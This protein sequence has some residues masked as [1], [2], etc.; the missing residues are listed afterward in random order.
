MSCVAQGEFQVWVAVG[1]LAG[2]KCGEVRVRG[3]R[4]GRW[5]LGKRG[6]WKWV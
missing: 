1:Y 4:V 3:G 2:M 6:M 5:A